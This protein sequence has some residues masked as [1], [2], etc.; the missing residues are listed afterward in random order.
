MST[1]VHREAVMGTI[2]TFEVRN[3][4]REDVWPGIER[5][6]AWLQWVDATFSPFR[7]DSEISRLDRGA[8]TEAECHPQVR[9]I[10]ALSEGLR[11]GTAGYF[12]VRAT[13]RLDPSGVVKGWSIETVSE[14]LAAAGW[15]DHLI[16]G[17]G[18]IRVHGRAGTD[19]DW[20]VGITHPLRVD[21]Y[22]AAVHLGAGAVATSGTYERGLH[23]IAPHRGCAAVD[24]AS[25]TV[26]GPELTMTDAYAT[27]ALAM[28]PAAPTWLEGLVDHE[29]LVIDTDG[30]GWETSGFGRYRL[31][32]SAAA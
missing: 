10:L 2:V 29:A 19:S 21:A 30:R 5:A 4:T 6:A 28:G 9:H 7:D 22:C 12:D 8:I 3:T 23:I 11:V 17:G 14:M 16:D 18:D 32:V 27:A 24:L 25:V 13:G 1:V 31:E 15:G 26:I 20:C